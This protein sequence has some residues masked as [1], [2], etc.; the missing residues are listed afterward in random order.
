M[1]GRM[2]RPGPWT[3][4]ED[5]LLLALHDSHDDLTI[6]RC[7]RVLARAGNPSRSRQAVGRRL[8]ELLAQRR[9][10][11]PKPRPRTRREQAP[12]A[13]MVLAVPLNDVER[14]G[15]DAVADLLAAA[16]PGWSWWIDDGE[17]ALDGA[18]ASARHQA[19]KRGELV[20]VLDREMTWG[21]L[22]AFAPRGTG[23]HRRALLVAVRFR[24]D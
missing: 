3:A 19:A 10:L 2:G 6:E 21:V 22:V 12:P 8:R 5:Q 4:R 18:L 24:R 13:V 17:E 15:R 9:A 11:A 20:V 14:R 16:V 7:A 23:P 1:I